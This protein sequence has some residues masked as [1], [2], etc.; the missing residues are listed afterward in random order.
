MS[1]LTNTRPVSI[2]EAKAPHGDPSG[3]GTGKSAR[4]GREHRDDVVRPG[5]IPGA[6][7]GL[8]MMAELLE[9]ASDLDFGRKGEAWG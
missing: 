6:M 1:E 7:I 5:R 8:V 3:G 4:G 2:L 9:I